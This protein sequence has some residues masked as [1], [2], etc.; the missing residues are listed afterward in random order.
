MDFSAARHNMVES[1]VR[2]NKVRD[3]L[4]LEAMETLPRENFVPERLRALAYMDEDISLGGGRALMEPMVL[5]RLLQAADVKAQDVALV[6]G[7][8]SGYEAAVL[9]KLAATVVALE[10]DKA[11]ADEAAHTLA[12]LGL[13]TVAVVEGA[14]PAGY[15]EQ[16]PYDVIFINGGVAEVPATL[17][18]QLADGGR[19][20]Y[21][22]LS[23]RGWGQAVLVNKQ[24]GVLSQIDLFDAACPLLHDFANAPKFTF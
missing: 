11:L 12:A 10:S 2:T 6:V 24:D 14:L 23:T 17:S 5:A 8:A 19:M 1:Q 13:D 15:P 9:S 21:V 7:C 22:A 18:D 20:V 3:P 4:V 16:G